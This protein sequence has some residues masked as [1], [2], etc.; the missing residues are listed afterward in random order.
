M[1]NLF[2]TGPYEKLMVIKIIFGIFALS[3]IGFIAWQGFRF[4]KSVGKWNI[5]YLAVF[6]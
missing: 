1:P 4:L 6:S 3:E 2:V 5:V